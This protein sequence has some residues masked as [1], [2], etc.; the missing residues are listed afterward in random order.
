MVLGAVR[1]PVVCL[2]TG[3]DASSSLTRQ[4][5]LNANVRGP[6]QEAAGGHDVLGG[7]LA[8][9]EVEFLNVAVH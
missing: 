5:I 1:L 4:R 2:W 7:F 8:C 9:A 3:W 6:A